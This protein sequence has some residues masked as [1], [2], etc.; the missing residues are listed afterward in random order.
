MLKEAMS[1]L[2]GKAKPIFH[3]DQGWQYQHGEVQKLLKEHG[4][5]PDYVKKRE[6]FRQCG[7]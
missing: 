3:S 2:K 5:T 4:L 7:C 1:K 6:L